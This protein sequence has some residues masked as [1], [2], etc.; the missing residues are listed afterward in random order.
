MRPSPP[1]MSLEWDLAGNLPLITLDP[2]LGGVLMENLFMLFRQLSTET[3]P[4]ML[5]T[6]IIENR[7]VFEI[8]SSTP[9]FRS[10]GGL[11]AGASL[12]LR[13]A[14]AIVESQGGS[15]DLSVDAERGIRLT[16]MLR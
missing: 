15:L 14:R 4:I 6:A 3:H 7:A 16:V 13:S 10:E 8:S 9:G 5:R 2:G 1:D 12:S 11:G